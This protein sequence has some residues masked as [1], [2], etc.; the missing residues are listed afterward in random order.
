MITLICALAFLPQELLA[1]PQSRKTRDAGW[2]YLKL[3][4]TPHQIGLD[5]GL[6]MA[7]E[8]DDAQLAL[9]AL[10]PLTSGKKWTFYRAAAKQIL[11]PKIPEEYREELEGQVEGL[12]AKG[13]SY[14]LT[15]LVAFNGYIELSEYYVPTLQ[16]KATS[17]ISCSAFVATGSQTTDGKIV[18]GHNLWWDYV[19]GPRFKLIL[20]IQPEHGNRIMMDAL[21]G[22]IHSGSDFAINQA[23]MMLCETTISGFKGFD[24][25]GIPEFVRMRKAIQ[26]GASI[27]AMAKIFRQGNNGGYANT[28]L[29]GDTK[30]NQIGK[31]ELGL[32]NVNLQTKSDGYFV[33]SNFPES[34]KLIADEI[35]EGWIANPAKNGCESRRQR[36][37]ELLNANVGKVDVE[38]A[39]KF[40]ADCIDY[41]TGQPAFNDRTLCGHGEFFGA[42]NTKVVDASLAKQMRF[43]ARMGFT[44]GVKQTVDQLLKPVPLMGRIR[45]Y[46]HDIASQPWIVVPLH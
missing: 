13:Y 9:R 22:F 18:M 16:G 45:P 6:L 21:P 15:D 1:S 39:Q 32:R 46:L 36:W 10:L 37:E 19:M 43:W 38:L 2:T 4:G 44:D 25:E 14:D 26:Y 20:D 8:I 7:A 23:G 35:P 24:P 34:P 29:M 42:V 41:S 17:Q 5:Y 31:L 11:M 30:T 40:L 28:W 3:S 27:E 33:G 12:R